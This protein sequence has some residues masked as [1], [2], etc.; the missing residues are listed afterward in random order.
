MDHL[1]QW[2]TDTL[3][4]VL[5]EKQI[6]TQLAKKFLAFYKTRRSIA[7]FMRVHKWNLFLASSIQSTILQCIS[8][9]R[10]VSY[11]VLYYLNK[12]SV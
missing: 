4:D 11:G 2:S 5:L 6:V 7:V 12:S 9:F 10:V 3:N 1:K 8:L